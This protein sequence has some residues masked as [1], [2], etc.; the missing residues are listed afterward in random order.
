MAPWAPLPSVR[1]LAAI[2]PRR[3]TPLGT[4]PRS[5]GVVVGA[6]R[7]PTRTV[8]CK[9]GRLPCCN[10]GSL[11]CR[12]I[13]TRG[14]PPVV[15]WPRCE[16]R[17]SLLTH[18]GNVCV[19]VFVVSARVI[20]GW[21]SSVESLDALNSRPCGRLPPSP[22]SSLGLAVF[23][24]GSFPYPTTRE[25]GLHVA[26]PG[27]RGGPKYQRHCGSVLVYRRHCGSDPDFVGC[28]FCSVWV[29]SHLFP[30]SC[31]ASEGPS[32][33]EGGDIALRPGYSRP[34]GHPGTTR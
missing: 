16:P 14:V 20:E 18:A 23:P 32:G 21:A 1:L 29:S 34:R 27:R 26:S 6:A 11:G 15:G 28:C 24:R 3:L 4:P 25:R 2:P 31:G 8:G 19:C 7:G 5:D 33:K 12:V 13:R 9:G 10:P 17:R 30:H 22:L